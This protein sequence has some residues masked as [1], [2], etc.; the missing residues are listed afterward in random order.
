[1]SDKSS[2]GGFCK[3]LCWLI[4]VAAGGYLAYELVNTYGQDQVQSAVIGIVAMLLVSLVT[5]RLVCRSGR[6][7]RVRNRIAEAQAL[8]DQGDDLRLDT[9]KAA[10]GPPPVDAVDA[11]LQARI[12]AA[13]S[14]AV[15]ATEDATQET[16]PEP[17]EPAPAKAAPKPAPA[18]KSAPK[19]TAIAGEM[20]PVDA[21]PASRKPASA[22]AAKTGL[23]EIVAKPASAPAAKSEDKT[24][25]EPAAKPAEPIKASAPA[26]ATEAEKPAA[27]PA[28]S[29]A[30]S[31]PLKAMPTKAPSS[32]ADTPKTTPEKPKPAP[33]A[34]TS[35][36]ETP[37]IAPLEPRGLDAP[38]G[39][40]ADDLK[41]IDGVGADQEK[42][43]NAAGIFHFQQFVGMN[44]RELAWIDQNI[45]D[46]QGEAAAENWR[47]QA[48][49]ITRKAG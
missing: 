33:V 13:A 22:P 44:R 2:E 36:H 15:E 46:A 7:N 34:A 37:D 42:A 10:A 27:S 43:L 3:L 29:D 19:H 21:L 32:E 18:E 40:K 11:G 5:R 41:Q 26:P 35:A 38:E 23:S 39:G 47:R 4:G 48:I 1:M 14:E 6:R 17:V 31:E 25:S 20:K 49:A 28:A 45:V 8:K 16:A 9:R 12:I 30:P 24:A